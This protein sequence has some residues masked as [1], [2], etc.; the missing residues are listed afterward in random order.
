MEKLKQ[1]A[2]KLKV[3]NDLL[4][5]TYCRAEKQKEP[6]IDVSNT[7][8]FLED[9]RSDWGMFLKRHLRDADE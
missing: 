9:L 2:R 5:L 6:E 7:E 3:L 1:N 8:D 4:I